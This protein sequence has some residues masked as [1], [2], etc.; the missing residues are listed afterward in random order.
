MISSPTWARSCSRR[1]TGT[2]PPWRRCVAPPVGPP[3]TRT[4]ARPLDPTVGTA[5]RAHSSRAAARA[6][7][8]CERRSAEIDATRTARPAR[9]L[10]V[11]TD[12]AIARTRG[13]SCARLMRASHAA[14]IRSTSRPLAAPLVSLA[15]DMSRARSPAAGP[16]GRL[17]PRVPPRARPRARRERRPVVASSAERTRGGRDTRRAWRG[18]G[19]GRPSDY[20]RGGGWGGGGG[21]GGRGVGGGGGGGG[22]TSNSGSLQVTDVGRRQCDV[23]DEVAGAGPIHHRDGL[24]MACRHSLL[25]ARA[26]RPATPSSECGHR[27]ASSVAA[28]GVAMVG[29]ARQT[30]S[31]ELLVRAIWHP[32]TMRSR[33]PTR[34]A[35]LRDA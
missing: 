16:E 23:V 19:L 5:R 1:S 8:P 25:E 30:P 33:L 9:A 21:G 13:S 32:V 6:A 2:T 29:I 20:P 26:I 3:T 15:G 14:A 18:H 11:R 24:V 17:R 22:G 4:V 7:G 31:A 34:A 27:S 12:V 35:R 28:A 10:S